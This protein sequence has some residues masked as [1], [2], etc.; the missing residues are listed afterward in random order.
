MREGTAR[1]RLLKCADAKK[2]LPGVL[3]VS[4]PPVV[5]RNKH[6]RSSITETKLT[7]D[8]TDRT[9]HFCR[10]CSSLLLSG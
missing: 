9:I 1:R 6:R 5:R 4:L 7:D 8:R 3:T 2:A 10:D